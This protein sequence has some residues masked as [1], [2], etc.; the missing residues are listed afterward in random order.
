MLTKKPFDMK[1]GFI[2]RFSLAAT[3][4]LLSLPGY[5]QK[6][7]KEKLTVTF[8]SSMHCED[9]VHTLTKSLA[10]EKGVTDLKFDLEKNLITIEYKNWKTDPGKLRKVILET[11]F[12]AEEV[13]EKEKEK[14][15][16]PDNQD[17]PEKT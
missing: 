12:K 2:A 4:L 3:L 1:K 17:T 5:A 15:K 9:C 16:D 7:L 6:P 8:H 11:G 13:K 10:F 14:E